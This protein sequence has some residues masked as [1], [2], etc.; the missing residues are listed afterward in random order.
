MTEPEPR[1]GGWK[2]QGFI[3][4]SRQS[5]EQPAT[6]YPAP[7]PRAAAPPPAPPPPAD[8]AAPDPSYE[9]VFARLWQRWT[10]EGRTVPGEPDPEWAALTRR[11]PWPR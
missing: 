2:R 11:S 9:P 3:P 7:P 8:P 4:V 5:S 6:P 10:T 1:G